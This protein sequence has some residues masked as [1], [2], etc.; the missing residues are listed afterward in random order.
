MVNFLPYLIYKSDFIKGV[1]VQETML[2]TEG[3]VLSKIS[4]T[5]GEGGSIVTPLPYT[6]QCAVSIV[7]LFKK[8]NPCPYPS[9]TC[10]PRIISVNSKTA[11]PPNLYF[12]V[13]TDVYKIAR[14]QIVTNIVYF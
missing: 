13:F 8:K 7:A 11:F 9:R 10:V 1:I 6:M 14:V 2:H 4:G 5:H 3:L 12:S